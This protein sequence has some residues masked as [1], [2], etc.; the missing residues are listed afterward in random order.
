LDEIGDVEDKF[1]DNEEGYEDEE[2][3][4]EE[5]DEDV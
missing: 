2:D 3:E 1:V 5:S 4:E